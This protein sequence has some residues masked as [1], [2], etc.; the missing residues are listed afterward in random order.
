MIIIV[1]VVVIIQIQSQNIVLLFQ[2]GTAQ[3]HLGTFEQSK[4]FDVTPR[5]VGMMLDAEFAV[6]FLDLVGKVGWWRYRTGGGAVAGFG[7]LE[8]G[9]VSV[10]CQH[11]HHGLGGSQR[12]RR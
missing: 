12:R 3:H 1:V 11:D 4:G 8:I 6:R 2:F 5:L 9:V 7:N 10:R